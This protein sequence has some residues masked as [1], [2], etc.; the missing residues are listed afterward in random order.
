MSELLLHYALGNG[1][2]ALVLA[3]LAWVAHRR[4][5]RPPRAVVLC[6]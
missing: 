4:G 5:A 3:A 6:V 1:L 2:V